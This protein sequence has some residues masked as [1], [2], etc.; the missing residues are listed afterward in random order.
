MI[1]PLRK[2]DINTHTIIARPSRTFSSSSA[3]EVGT[4]SIYPKVNRVLKEVTKTSGTLYS[5]TSAPAAASSLK[6]SIIASS[7]NAEKVAAGYLAHARALTLSQRA[8]KTKS[9]TRYVPSFTQ[10]KIRGRKNVIKNLLM[11][12]NR[13]E[14]NSYNWSFSNYHCINFFSASGI[15]N[16]YAIMYPNVTS[17]YALTSSTQSQGNYVVTGAFTFDFHIKIKKPTETSYKAGT[18]YHL[19]SCYAV[20]VISGSEKDEA[21]RASN[22]RVLLQLGRSAGT[23]PSLALLG[24]SPNDLIFSSSAIMSAS[25]WHHVTI[26]WGSNAV[27]AGTGTFIIDGVNAGTFVVPSSSINATYA[28]QYGGNPDVLV[29]G[30]FYEGANSST[31][32]QALWFSDDPSERYG[33]T[34]LV[35]SPATE[36]PGVYSLDHPLSAELHDISLMRDYYPSQSD[37]TP[38]RIDRNKYALYIPP[39]FI[40]A[41]PTR[42]FV[43][44]HGGVLQSPFFEEDGTTSH[45]F[46]TTLAFGVGGKEINVENF[47][48][49]WATETWPR[50]HELTSSAISTTTDVKNAD[51]HMYG[52]ATF[53]RR[54]V[55]ILPCDDGKFFPRYDAFDD[56]ADDKTCDS[57][58]DADLGWVSLENMVATSS[59][60]LGSFERED[61]TSTNRRSN[62]E[63]QLSKA[64]PE[65]PSEDPDNQLTIYNRTRDNSSDLV[66]MFDVPS[67][68][69]GRSIDRGSVKLVDSAYTGTL[70]AMKFVLRD[71]GNGNLYRADCAEP[72]TWNSVGNVFY[73]EGIILVKS[74]I[75]SLFGKNQFELSF[76][77]YKKVNV[78]SLDVAAHPLS[79]NSSSNPSWNASYSPT[80]VRQQKGSYHTWLSSVN[81]HDE[82]MNVI[83]R[84]KLA[85]PFLKEENDEVTFRV[86]FDFLR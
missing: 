42:S 34:Q 9:I 84:A 22:F 80:A 35:S 64:L 69:Y 36:G 86:K 45:P 71:D 8:S 18:I 79:L 62:I 41:S 68:F 13:P 1:V 59:L 75:F 74:P 2:E 78:M 43:S 30:N 24:N 76:R 48:R 10:N 3:G 65:N 31:N 54:N 85:Q 16:K 12:H 60:H 14:G 61:V 15:S 39:V 17:S 63:R 51:D 37:A 25:T 4:V 40:S 56:Y 19:S 5:D 38:L 7:I 49:D 23:K 26:A 57:F 58:G 6:A 81:I 33:I 52:Q 83:V 73:D 11:P 20:S 53:G 50:L 27:N 70:G 77:G 55:T 67:A 72:A 46:N 66:V 32:A 28:Q 82:D 21:N 29:L 47:V 44:T